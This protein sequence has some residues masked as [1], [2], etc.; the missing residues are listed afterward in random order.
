[1]KNQI[2]TLA[3]NVK[4]KCLPAKPSI[5]EVR[6]AEL[7]ASCNHYIKQHNIKPSLKILW[8][9]LFNQDHTW[10]SHDGM[11]IN[12]LKVRGVD[13]IPTM[14]DQLQ[15]QE[16]MIYGGVWQG[17]TE[18]GF[19]ERRKE[20]CNQCLR[21]DLKLW[22]ILD[23]K[24]IRLTSYIT[25][26]E[27]AKLWEEVKTLMKGDWQ[28]V[29]VDG[30]PVGKEAWKAVVNNN[31][32]GEIKPYWQEV[33]NAQAEHHIFNILSLKLVYERILNAIAPDRIVG[34]GGYYYQWGILNELCQ[35][36]DIPY[37]RYY[38]LGLQPMAWNYERNTP[39][40][41][42]LSPAWSTW[43]QQPFSKEQVKRVKEDLKQ[44][45]M[46]IDISDQPEIQSRIERIKSELKLD[47]NKPVLLALSGIIWD[48]NTNFESKAFKNMYHWV[49]ETIKWFEQH[50]EF[51]LIIRTHPCE[52]IVPSVA[53]DERTTLI[54]ELGLSEIKI[55]P[56]VIVIKPEEKYD[57][58]DL[59]HISSAAATYMS[60]TG[61][62]YCCLGKPLLA[63]GP[64]HY[65]DKGFTFEPT[66]KEN[67]FALLQQFMKEPLSGEQGGKI[68]E[69]AMRYWYLYAFHASI[70]TGL[71]E[72]AHTDLT[73]MKRGMAGFHSHI[74]AISVADILPG[75]NEKLDYVCDSIMKNLPIFGENRWPP[76]IHQD[77]CRI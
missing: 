38:Y 8:P 34:N 33:A 24:P 37:F 74:R 15:S 19:E 63:I 11:L 29:I 41:I 70:V 18:P 9:T 21:A 16:C 22:E 49:I 65:T 17:A 77:L 62:E 3:R 2:L 73:S 36:R 52:N 75:V 55:P 66:S 47:P 50:P 27:K 56:N 68:Q 43:A 7:T 61:L 46:H 10:W 13:V 60:T 69:L 26:G 54:R 71:F 53:P 45:S 23:I 67:Y 58:Y 25:P 5:T 72:T 14:C 28:N 1:M 40:L 51:Q 30:Y 42:H 64:S 76:E 59:V 32:Q 12:A 31:L 35:R 39:A 20:L 6:L 48:A 4:K 44:R 57:T